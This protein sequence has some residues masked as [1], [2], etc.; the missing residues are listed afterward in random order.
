[1]L[2]EGASLGLRQV[3]CHHC[4]RR[5][6]AAR[7]CPHCGALLADATTSTVAFSR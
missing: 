2:D 7:F 6:E 1:V 5:L 3:R 4:G